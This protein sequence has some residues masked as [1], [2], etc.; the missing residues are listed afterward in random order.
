VSI[1]CATE[2]PRA[3]AWGFTGGETPMR[4]LSALLLGEKLIEFALLIVV[5][6]SKNS[7]LAVA[8]DIPIIQAE[9]VENSTQFLRLLG[10]EVKLLCPP[11][12]RNLFTALGP[13]WKRAM[14]PLMTA[15]AHA[16][17]S[18][19]YSGQEDQGDRQDASQS[20][21]SRPESHSSG[22]HHT[23]IDGG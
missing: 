19:D 12:K 23:L 11:L 9:I 4:W 17:S 21:S 18:G 3:D 15:D 7:G 2:G 13:E 8:Q 1:D 22:R 16:D 20:G 5:E 14:Q 10:A 6:D